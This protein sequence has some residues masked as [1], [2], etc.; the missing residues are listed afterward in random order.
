MH[1]CIQSSYSAAGGIK[2][3]KLGWEALSKHIL[4]QAPSESIKPCSFSL[5]LSWT[6]PLRL[7]ADLSGRHG[8]LYRLCLHA[9]AHHGHPALLRGYPVTHW[10]R[11]S[12]CDLLSVGQPAS[13]AWFRAVSWTPGRDW[14]WPC[15]GGSS[16]LFSKA[17][18]ISK[19]VLKVMLDEVVPSDCFSSKELYAFDQYGHWG[20][21]KV[22]LIPSYI[23][24]L[25]WLSTPHCWQNMW[26]M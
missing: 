21:V 10:P 17:D 9:A 22:H 19:Y 7:P 3:P 23:F 16:L 25:L 24:Y 5:S 4:N 8:C 26:I 6:P 1:R 18:S 20:G 14:C 2:L 11:P 12:V 13:P 15:W